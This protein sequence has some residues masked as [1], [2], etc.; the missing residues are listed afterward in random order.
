MIMHR[1]LPRVIEEFHNILITDQEN[2]EKNMNSIELDSDKIIKTINIIN[3]YG[4]GIRDGESLDQLTRLGLKFNGGCGGIC[5]YKIY[6]YI[7]HYISPMTQDMRYRYSAAAVLFIGYLSVYDDFS[8]EGIV[9][10][11]R[12]I[13][14]DHLNHRTI[15]GEN[16]MFS[17]RSEAIAMLSK[18]YENS[19]AIEL[20]TLMKVLK[21]LEYDK[22]RVDE[23][24]KRMSLNQYT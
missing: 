15:G 20:I 2:Q 16:F 22:D 7:M 6:K 23:L 18:A 13:L 10:R 11:Y 4:W 3:K 9:K 21:A 1:Y 17:L 8:A 5:A 19:E 24:K 12:R 14:S